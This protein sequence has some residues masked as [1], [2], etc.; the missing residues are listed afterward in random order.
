MHVIGDNLKCIVEEKTSEHVL[1]LYSSKVD[2]GLI[3][4]SFLVSMGSGEDAIIVSS[5]DSSKI[6]KELDFIDD[7]LKVLRFDEM[8]SLEDEVNKQAELRLIIDAGSLPSQTYEQIRER[9][10][11]L[12]GF[13]A[14]KPLRCLCTYRING[15]SEQAIRPLSK[16]HSLLQLTTSDLTLISGEFMESLQVSYDS[17]K[18]NVKDNLDVI[19]LAL[20]QERAMTGLDIMKT[21]NMEFDVLLSPGAVYPLLDSL[22][23][24]GLLS[25]LRMGK[26]RVYKTTIESKSEIQQMIHD[27]IQARK[28]LNNYLQSKSN[29]LMEANQ[30]VDHTKRLNS[31]QIKRGPW[32]D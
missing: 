16:L 3:H 12:I 25:S 10:Q 23:R 17:I 29:L 24:K 15:L 26:E 19:I 7:R 8:S 2:K 21:I 30:L 4:R 28:M 20:I 11:N 14:K 18:K 6:R 9:E 13:A 31:K 5:D 22:Q 1:H 32:L 27:Q